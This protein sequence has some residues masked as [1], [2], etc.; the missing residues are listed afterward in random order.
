MVRR[1]ALFGP[2]VIGLLLGCGQGDEPSPK[3]SPTAAPTNTG[4][5]PVASTT[6]SASAPAT[7]HPWAGVW[8]GR[9][10]AKKGAVGVPEGVAYPV[11]EK[12]KGDDASGQ[13]T[14]ELTIAPDGEVTGQG[15]GALGAFVLRGRADQK[16]V[17]SGVSPAEAETEAAMTGVFTAR[18]KQA[19]KTLEAKLQVA[20]GKGARVRTA[21]FVLSKGALDGD[22]TSDGT[23][24]PPTATSSAKGG[25]GEVA[26]PPP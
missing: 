4:A 13:G 22:A 10:E 5:A 17:R 11:W 8:S 14:I 26:A 3:P 23:T 25:S 21:T 2:L 24:P 15:Q 6:S 19:G 1:P 20:G 16:M 12:E 7:A 18:E 9:F